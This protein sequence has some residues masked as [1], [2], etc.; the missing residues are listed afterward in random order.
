MNLLKDYKLRKARIDNMIGKFDRT[1]KKLIV[2]Y[3]LRN[4]KKQTFR[5]IIYLLLLGFALFV[6][7]ALWKRSEPM[8]FWTGLQAVVVTLASLAALHELRAFV[9]TQ[10]ERGARGFVQFAEHFMGSDFLREAQELETVI[11]LDEDN[12]A[13]AHDVFALGLLGRLEVAHAYI[14]RGLMDRDILFLSYT[15]GFISVALAFRHLLHQRKKMPWLI[16]QQ[17]KYRNAFRLL[18]D[19]EDWRAI[20]ERTMLYEDYQLENPR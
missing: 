14:T 10:L 7:I 8:V 5:I 9:G 11:G 3:W 12:R 16:E 18:R 1:R 13:K 17:E 6:A 15:G 4:H 2:K 19:F 20:R